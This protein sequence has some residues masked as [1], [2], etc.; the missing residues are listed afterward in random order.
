MKYLQKLLHTK[1]PS[2]NQLLDIAIVLSI[3]P[4][5]FVMKFFML[6]YIVIA[7]FFL[8]KKR[9]KT[10]DKYLLMI[11]GLAL[12]F[13]SFFSNYNFSDF[14]RMQF[15]VSLVSSLLIYAVSLQKLT[16]EV[17]FY[18][19]VSPAMLMI[20]SFFFFNSITMLVY[21]TFSIFL[22]TLLY[23]W[24]RM[25]VALIEVLKFT[26][27]I[28]IVS[29]PLVALLFMVFPRISIQKADFGFRADEYA[30]SGYDGKMKVG[31]REIHLSNRIIMEVL[32]ENENISDE[33]LYF[34]G[35]TLSVLDGLEWK[36]EALNKQRDLLLQPKDI[37]NYAITIYPHAK[38]WIYALEMP[39][40]V[41]NK[42]TLLYD[43]TISSDKPL[44][45]MKK[46]QLSAA[47]S[48]KLHSQNLSNKLLV[49]KE[50]SEQT[51]K[52]LTKIKESNIVPQEKAQALLNFFLKQKLVYTL[53]PIGTDLSD[54]TDSFLFES[55]NGYCIHFASVFASSARMLGI[56]SRVVT[57]FKA[58]KTS[59]IKNY[60]IVRALDA[61]AWVELYFDKE[62]WVRFDPTNT[63]TKN[64]SIGAQVTNNT[65]LGSS[66]LGKM[67]QYY[68]YTKYIISNWILD[69][70]R[71]K[72]MAIL[73]KMLNDTIYLLKVIFSFLVLVIVSTLLYFTI[74]RSS[75]EDKVLC[76][77]QKL[78]KFLNKYGLTK[79]TSQTMESFLQEAQKELNI[80]FIE[81]NEIYNGLKYKKEY[82]KSD[83]LKLK[84]EIKR[85]TKEIKK[86]SR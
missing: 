61:H 25:D 21:S 8:L 58:D 2:N 17:N 7:L 63:A 80:S 56:P 76:E 59:M 85:L 12:I 64:L 16:Q 69:Y 82:H 46:Y 39:M 22:F 19:K 5:L 18:L 20:L 55:K 4:H 42:A 28:F 73:H 10:S 74:K 1:A 15:F 38:K 24:S 62:G 45:E 14:S 51:Y 30:V 86:A 47:L 67:N 36:Q 11:I 13:V 33:Q 84:Y 75:S 77:M 35:T 50:K 44:Y 43:Y 68:M 37:I 65:M 40:Q 32:F 26:S 31:D 81:L 41:P 83:L 27:R 29:L 52:A 23:I 60:L 72:Q 79:A 3:I 9:R 34:R 54:F 66:T 48:Y 53:K 71:T 78:F 49:D 70:N 57:G 6:L